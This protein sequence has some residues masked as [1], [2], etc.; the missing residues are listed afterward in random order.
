MHVELQAAIAETL[1]ALQDLQPSHTAAHQQ[2]ELDF[3]HVRVL[4]HAAKLGSQPA[5][6]NRMMAA[7]KVQQ[8]QAAALAQRQIQ[9]S[10]WSPQRMQGLRTQHLVAWAAALSCACG[11]RWT[12]TELPRSRCARQSSSPMTNGQRKGLEAVQGDRPGTVNHTIMQAE[13]MHSMP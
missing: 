9:R 2:D 1:Q 7:G 8:A 11:L 3:R 10:N 5:G 4:A 6:L 12:R 13:D